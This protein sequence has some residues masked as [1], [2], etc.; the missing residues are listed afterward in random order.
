MPKQD[1]ASRPFSIPYGSGEEQFAEL[2]APRVPEGQKGAD[3]RNALLTAGE[4]S[5]RY[6]SARIPKKGRVDSIELYNDEAPMPV[7]AVACTMAGATPPEDGETPPGHGATGMPALSLN[8]PTGRAC[9]SVSFLANYSDPGICRPISGFRVFSKD[10]PPDGY[11]SE[12]ALQ[13]VVTGAMEL[14]RR[15]YNWS[16]AR[17]LRGTNVRRRTQVVPDGGL[18]SGELGHSAISPGASTSGLFRPAFP[19]KRLGEPD[20][21]SKFLYTEKGKELAAYRQYLQTRSLAGG[22]YFKALREASLKAPELVFGKYRACTAQLGFAELAASHRQTAKVFD[23]NVERV[24]YDFET[25]FA[26]TLLRGARRLSA[27]R[28][29]TVFRSTDSGGAGAKCLLGDILLCAGTDNSGAQLIFR[30]RRTKQPV[31]L[32]GGSD[33]SKAA[34]KGWGAILDAAIYERGVTAL[35]SGGRVASYDLRTLSIVSSF[36][37][38]SETVCGALH[39]Q[40]GLFATS[41][42]GNSLD[43]GWAQ[44]VSIGRSALGPSEV[45]CL[46]WHPE[47][48]ILACA[49]CS[50]IQLYRLRV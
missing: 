37:L 28:P 33:G 23:L 38:G 21:T 24:A 32:Q 29:G 7:L 14:A 41:P 12:S 18:Y 48:E 40:V 8:R 19:S 16:L 31:Y 4:A 46:A 6:F 1:L 20:S 44:G 34:P 35:Y 3:A 47:K 5:K 17:Y 13:A 50:G 15:S 36:S 30:D 39:P 11:I 22:R 27:G 2:M 45:Q 9:T 49:G 25:N 43:L 10:P 26:I 42:E